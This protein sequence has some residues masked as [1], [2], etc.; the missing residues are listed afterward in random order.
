[1][2]R[3]VI[4]SQ[5]SWPN[6]L[7]QAVY[8][9]HM[10]RKLVGGQSPFEFMFGIPSMY[11]TSL[12]EPVRCVNTNQNVRHVGLLAAESMRAIGTL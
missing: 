4:D 1:M 11:M 7:R 3:V 2:R 6:S 10:I 8:G 9:Y 12:S 5:T